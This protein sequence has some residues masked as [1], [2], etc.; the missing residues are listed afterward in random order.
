MVTIYYLSATGNSLYMARK[1]EQLLI[2]PVQLRSIAQAMEAKDFKPSGTVGFVL[3]LH[4]FSLPLLAED[5]LQKL[6]LSEAEYTFGIVTAGFHYISDASHELSARVQQAGGSLEAFFYVDMVS[7]YL[8]LND[9]PAQPVIDRRLQK[10]VQRMEKIAGRIAGRQKVQVREIF[11]W[12]SR[13]MHRLVQKQP[14]KL[15][16]EFLP[17]AACTGCGLCERICPKQNIHL[18]DNRP[19][20]QHHCTQCLA[21][22]HACPQACIELGQR[23]KGRRRYHHPEIAIKDLL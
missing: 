19:Q 22:L 7:V 10:A 21:C 6:D 23:T 13:F 3:P 5:F 17:G 1:L 8:P 20:W 12:P 18:E 16:A 9:L 15:D 2:E 14:E 11:A 4:F